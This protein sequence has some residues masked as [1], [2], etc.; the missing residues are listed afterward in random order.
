MTA[1]KADNTLKLVA[2][3]MTITASRA[4]RATRT[5]TTMTSITTRVA[6]KMVT[7]R[8]LHQAVRQGV[9]SM[10]RRRTLRPSATS[11]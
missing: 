3:T 2:T 4:S 9:A 6:L 7:P 8:M 1:S 5:N 11:Q 10:I